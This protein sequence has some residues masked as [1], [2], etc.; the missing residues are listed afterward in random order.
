MALYALTEQQ[1]AALRQY[2]ECVQLLQEELGIEPEPETTKLYEA[3]RSRKFGKEERKAGNLKAEVINKKKDIDQTLHKRL[4]PLPTP[5]TPFIGRE[6]ELAEVSALLHKPETRLLTLVGAGGMGKTRLALAVG[7]AVADRFHN[8]VVFIPLAPLSAPEHIVPTI[9]NTLNVG[10][11]G[12]DPQ[13]QLLDYLRDKEMLLLVDNFEHLLL[14]VGLLLAILQEAPNV[15]LLVTSRERL[16]LTSEAVFVLGGLPVI[17][18][19]TAELSQ[20]FQLFQQHTRLVRPNLFL[21][22]EDYQT[23]NQICKLVDGMPLAL[24][25][26]ASWSEVLTFAEIAEEIGHS[27]DF[28]ETDMAD[29]PLRQRSI[30]AVFEGSWRRLTDEEKAVFSQLSLFRGGFTRQAAL[31]VTGTTLLTIRSLVQKLFL[32]LEANGR[33]QIHELLRQYGTERLKL[34]NRYLEAQRSHATYYFDMLEKFE[35]DYRSGRQLEA[36]AELEVEWENIRTAWRWQSEQQSEQEIERALEGLQLYTEA[37]GRFLDGIHLL[38]QAQRPLAPATGRSF[39]L[40]WSKL[41][42]R[43]HFMSAIAIELDRSLEDVIAHCLQIAQQANDPFEIAFCLYFRGTASVWFNED[44][45][46][47]H[48]Y[49]LQALE[50]FRELGDDLFVG[51]TFMMLESSTKH[52]MNL[53]R[54]YMQEAIKIFRANDHKIEGC[55]TLNNFC[56]NSMI[57]GDYEAAEK[58]GREGLLLA[59]EINQGLHLAYS[60]I[61]YG[62]SLLFVGKVDSAA[63]Q[64]D[65]EQ[66]TEFEHY[67]QLRTYT[68]LFLSLHAN[69]RETYET[70]RQLAETGLANPT[71]DTFADVLGAWSMTQAYL[72]LGDWESARFYL[73]QTVER[74]RNERSVAMLTWVLP[75]MVVLHSQNEAWET[76][77]H[78]LALAYTHPLSPTDYFDTWPLLKRTEAH[79]R[80]V[81]GDEAYLAAWNDGQTLEIE[82]LFANE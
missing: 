24:I 5:S 71:G 55:I 37:V 61:L 41:T 76:A 44:P 42:A 46:G 20:A 13:S 35:E 17:H 4:P 25:L 2:E 28:L 81:L 54:Y 78:H 32:T 15:K 3:I 36:I 66:Q 64:I 1:A 63:E 65:E 57:W 26:A 30:R 21:Q 43:I 9:A 6:Q 10:L 75:C 22:T 79:L 73:K 56:E 40:A 48:D 34:S 14:G 19:D 62:L 69:L 7:T 77:V 47:S 82:R 29:M 59:T 45:E 58:L 16:N 68:E 80:R 67:V 52:E 53:S 60:K 70:A 50:R 51:R 38:Q 74:I 39:S 23:I 49:L 11:R 8:G 33:Y 27:L 12:T 18:K 72:G 31:A